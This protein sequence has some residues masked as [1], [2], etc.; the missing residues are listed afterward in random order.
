MDDIAAEPADEP[1]APVAPVE[2]VAPPPARRPGGMR[3]AIEWI[4]IIVGA[5]ILAL[6]VKTLVLQAFYIPSSSMEDTL[7]I[8]DRVL[9]NKLSYHMHAVHRGDIVVFKRPKAE[10]DPR[11]KDLIKRVIGMPGETI[12]GRDGHVFVDGRELHESYIKTGTDTNNL[13]KVT[14]P[15]GQYFVLGD[16]RTNSKDSR[17]FGPIPRSLIVGRAFIRV[18]PLS[19][20][21]L[22]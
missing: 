3:S 8:G 12:E 13:G 6:V 7:D 21:G 22:L 4:A 20:L 18:W 5:L 11:V 14:I 1:V 17:S 19:S 15:P 9:V 2:P 16:N 10:S